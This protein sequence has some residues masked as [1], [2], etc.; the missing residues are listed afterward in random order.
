[1][2]STMLSEE[3]KT[4]EKL[5]ADEKIIS[6]TKYNKV[7]NDEIAKIKTELSCLLP[8]NETVFNNS[9]IL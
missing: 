4:C 5:L 6:E 2:M 1:M 8:F 7:M 3:R 9:A